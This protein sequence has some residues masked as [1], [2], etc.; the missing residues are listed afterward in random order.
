MV[1]R[2]KKSREEVEPLPTAE[3]FFLLFMCCVQALTAVPVLS[4]LRC[5]ISLFH[6]CDATDFTTAACMELARGDGVRT[7]CLQSFLFPKS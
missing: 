6:M 3:H 4:M 1:P 2:S 5:A 7:L